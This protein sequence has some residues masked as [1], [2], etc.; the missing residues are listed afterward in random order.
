MDTTRVGLR[1]LRAYRS[2]C[3][4][5]Q[6]IEERR[7]ELHAQLDRVL[8]VDARFDWNGVGDSLN[9]WLSLLRLG[10]AAGRATFLW[11][12]DEHM[13]S[14]ARPRFD[15][16]GFFV[17][18]GADWQWSLGTRARVEQRM[19]QHAQPTVVEYA[20]VQRSGLKCNRPRLQWASPVP[21]EAMAFECSHESPA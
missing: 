19:G 8:V 13:V 12:S 5:T 21:G 1:E 18:D 11:L 20:C 6:K 4:C 17:A 15:L 10:L 7:A 2:R 9:R 3:A 16:G 14:Q